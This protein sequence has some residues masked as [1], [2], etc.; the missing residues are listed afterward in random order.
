M[1]NRL[2][3]GCLGLK[4]FPSAFEILAGARQRAEGSPS[5]GMERFNVSTDE[6]TRKNANVIKTY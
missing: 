5:I 4:P 2:A 3:K 6:T 1:L